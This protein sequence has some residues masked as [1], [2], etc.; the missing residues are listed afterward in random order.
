[1]KERKHHNP[2]QK[3]VMLRK[4][5][6]NKVHLSQRIARGKYFLKLQTNSF[7]KTQKLVLIK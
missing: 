3:V 4:L 1:M 7:I 5:R 6:E 2:G